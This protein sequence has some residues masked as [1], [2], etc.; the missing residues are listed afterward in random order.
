MP[1]YR[2]RIVRPLYRR[3]TLYRPYRWSVTRRTL[4]RY[5]R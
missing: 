2:R 4:R 3:R 5:R 1:L